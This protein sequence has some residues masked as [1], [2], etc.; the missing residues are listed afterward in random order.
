V[1][2]IVVLICLLFEHMI[3]LDLCLCELYCGVMAT[4]AIKKLIVRL[5]EIVWGLNLDV[6]YFISHASLK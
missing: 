6:F 5:I 4:N 3:D 1:K 2:T